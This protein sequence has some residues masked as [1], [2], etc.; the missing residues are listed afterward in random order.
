M[1]DL[2]NRIAAVLRLHQWR[3]TVRTSDDDPVLD[4][5][6]GIAFGGALDCQRD[7]FDQHR[8]HVADAVI[9]ELGLKD[10]KSGEPEKTLRER[11][12]IAVIEALTDDDPFVLVAIGD[13]EI[14]VNWER[15]GND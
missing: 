4:C 11:V 10:E 1:S 9:R 13:H 6:C 2:R 8:D 15:T 7:V 14:H 3:A 12:V 5:I